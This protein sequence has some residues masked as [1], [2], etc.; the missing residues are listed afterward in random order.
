M[1]RYISFGQK[2]FALV[3]KQRQTCPPFTVPLPK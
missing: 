3:K 1:S 2:K